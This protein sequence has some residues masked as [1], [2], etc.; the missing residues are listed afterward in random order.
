MLPDRSPQPPQAAVPAQG[1]GS[2]AA[3]SFDIARLMDEPAALDAWD[4]FRRGERGAFTRQLYTPE[5]QRTFEEV[6]LRYRT[7]AAFRDT[8]N[9]Y[10]QEF[11]RLLAEV[12]RDDRDGSVSRTYLA[13]ETGKVYTLL[14]HAS[15]RLD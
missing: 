15:G 2:L 7:D 3:L 13:S 6:G 4:R 11:E 5:G 10:T 1:G 8:V 14:A 12:S 9:R